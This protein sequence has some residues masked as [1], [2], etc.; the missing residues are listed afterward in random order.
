MRFLFFLLGFMFLGISVYGQTIEA[1]NDSILK[2]KSTDPKKGIIFGFE[3]INSD[4]EQI[5][6]DF[7]NSYYLIAECFYNMGFYKKSFQYLIEAL[8][9]YESMDPKYRV[10]PNVLKPPWVLI[11]MG[12]VYFKNKYYDKAEGY[13]QEALNNFRLYDDNKIEKFFGLNTSESNLGLVE[14]ERKNFSKA[15]MIYQKILNRKVKFGRQLDILQQYLFFM[16]LYFLWDKEIIAE[17]YFYKI[18]KKEKE[19]H[20]YNNRQEFI[21][22]QQ[23]LSSANLRFGQYLKRNKRYGEALTFF[24]KAKELL[25]DVK[26]QIPI[27]NLQIAMCYLDQGLTSKAE[28]LINKT[29]ENFDLG[30]EEKLISLELLESIYNRN[31]DLTNQL[32]MKDSIIA[33]NYNLSNDI[34]GNEFNMLEG[35]L[36]ISEKQ[37]EIKQIENE[38]NKIFQFSI[39]SIFTLIIISLTL[40]INYNL[41]KEKNSR[42]QLEKDKINSELTYHK[43]EL[44]SKVNFI[45]QRNDYINRILT[46]FDKNYDISDR[47]KLLKLKLSIRNISNSEK[48]YEEFDKI[49][50]RVYPEFYKKLCSLAKL[51]QTDLRL[52]SYIKMN[53]TIK[54]ISKISGVP[55]RTVE[56]QRY[57]LKKK[58]GLNKDED[59]NSYI[60]KI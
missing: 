19:Q 50:V 34:G 11:L 14:I 43:R 47:N 21:E 20:L 24:Y 13:Y 32:R 22:I 17:E 27:V 52:A 58:L 37:N 60:K 51:G 4:V 46:Q 30:F 42:L 23:V 2:Y 39:M 7:F 57:R 25:E 38:K 16:N 35:L 36:S 45:S 28:N 5:N 44:I 26:F 3:A 55:L 41:Q 31:K 8:K 48:A 49:F 18:I 59:L 12:N 40:R 54:E 56:T 15:E 9:I 33:L 10:N 6:Y 29:K 53:H 1:L